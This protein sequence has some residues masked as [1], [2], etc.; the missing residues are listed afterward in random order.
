MQLIEITDQTIWDDF[1]STSPFGHPLQLWAWGEVKKKN[2]WTP[3]RLGVQ[4]GDHLE[5]AIQILFWNIPKTSYRLA[6]VPRGPVIDPLSGE[7]PGLLSAIANAAKA[8][9][10]IQL[11]IEPAWKNVKLGS[12][13][14]LSKDNVLLAETYAIDLNQEEDV[15]LGNIQS[16]ARQY[17]RKADREG[18]QIRRVMDSSELPKV[19]DVYTDTATRAKFALHQEEYYRGL[20]EKGGKHNYLLLA[21]KDGQAVAFVWIVAA[22]STAFELYGGMTREG[23][24]LHANYALKAHAMQQ[25]KA[26][27]FKI[28]DFNGRLNDGVSHFKSLWGAEET[29]WIGSY[30]LP[31]KSLHYKAWQVA[32]PI[33]KKL[34]KIGR[35]K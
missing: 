22:G 27:G 8:R 32:W 9:G 28:Y 31:L 13:W 20:L 34:S 23:A 15:L 29:D 16:K 7:L 33:G 10:A 1:V 18:V 2:G 26:E 11:K 12:E 14:K 19:M 25:M 4:V 21:K 17:I 24:K 30:N 3:L 5:A 35:K 6:Y